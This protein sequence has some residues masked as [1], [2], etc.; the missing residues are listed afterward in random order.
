MRILL[1]TDWNPRQG[2]AEN[3]IG[4]LRDGLLEAG[5]DARLLTSSTGSAGDGAADYVAYGS[6]RF[7]AQI[8]LQIRNPFAVMTV[9]RA[10]AELQPGVAIGCDKNWPEMASAPRLFCWVYRHR[11]CYF[12][13]SPQPIP[14]LF[15]V[16]VLI[17]KRGSICCYEHSPGFVPYFLQRAY[18]LSGADRSVSI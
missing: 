8:F 6:E 18:A 3:Y 1:I 13:G 11:D 4:W 9:K 17:V 15:F 2:G 7:A 5:D 16:G 12:V 14:F 10:L